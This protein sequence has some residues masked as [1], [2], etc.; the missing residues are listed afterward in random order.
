MNDS[1]PLVEERLRRLPGVV[2]ARIQTDAAGN[3]VAVHVR[4]ADGSDADRLRDHVVALF[5]EAGVAIS[6]VLVHLA[7]EPVFES[8][9]LEE[10]EVEGR[11]RL[12]A[13][14][15]RVDDTGTHAEVELAFGTDHTRGAASLHG[16][17]PAPEIL[18]LACLDALERLC[19]ARVTL[20]LAGVQRTTLPTGEV[21]CVAVQEIAGRTVRVHSGIAPA[22][23]DPA[24]A[25]AYA[26]LGACNRP[27]GRILTGPTRHIDLG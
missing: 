19:H 14:Q 16:G 15:T 5:A 13:F 12:V 9:C 17:A 22:G 10:L 3:P 27:F 21:Y 7:F 24:R 18:A 2:D 20:R 23:E 6:P 4:A 8:G 26:V 11:V 25:I 1:I